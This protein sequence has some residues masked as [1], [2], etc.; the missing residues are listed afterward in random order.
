MSFLDATGLGTFWAKLKNYFLKKS[1][2]DA[3]VTGLTDILS[4]V[5]L[6]PNSEFRRTNTSSNPQTIGTL[7]T[8]FVTF[9][10]YWQIQAFSGTCSNVTLSVEKNIGSRYNLLSI[11][12]T[13]ATTSTNSDGKKYV[14]L[15]VRNTSLNYYRNDH[16]WYTDTFKLE[17]VD[18]L[19]YTLNGYG[20]HSGSEGG[21]IR[22]NGL[23]VVNI[24]R[25][26]GA[27]TLP[28]FCM[29]LTDI[30]EGDTFQIRLYDCATYLGSYRN[31]PVIPSLDG[32]PGNQFLLQN[33]L[34]Y[35]PFNYVISNTTYTANK[36]NR[37]FYLGKRLIL[38]K[39][40]YIK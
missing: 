28:Y 15:R 34:S 6:M 17:K 39:K 16:I 31:P 12:G 38:N 26:S 24:F 9:A 29:T 25:T 22:T 36:W 27:D 14:T 40:H 13:V 32:M 4:P 11:S 23:N 21:A 18:S 7:N 19:S 10:D 8:T 3:P 2:T 30:N 35:C 33:G 5:N 20:A 1:D 37:V